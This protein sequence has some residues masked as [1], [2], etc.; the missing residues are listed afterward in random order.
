MNYWQENLEFFRK[1]AY[2]IYNKMQQAEQGD[3]PLEVSYLQDKKV[4]QVKRDNIHVHLASLFDSKREIKKT[5]ERCDKDAGLVLLLGI[6]NLALIKE[7][8]K[9]FRQIRRFIIVEPSVNIFNCAMKNMSVRDIFSAYPDTNITI[10]LQED[11]DIANNY[12]RAFMTIN[13]YETTA[14]VYTVPYAFVFPYEKQKLA[15]FVYFG[16][17]QYMVTVNTKKFFRCA[18]HINEW[19]NLAVEA[20]PLSALQKIFEQLPVIVVSAGPSLNKNIHLLK[21]VGNRAIIITAGSGMSILN[22]HGIKPHFRFCVEGN[23]FQERLFDSLDVNDSPLVFISAMYHKIVQKYE[24]NSFELFTSKSNPIKKYVLE[25][26]SMPMSETSSGSSVSNVAVFSSLTLG[27]KKIILM[28]QDL[29]FTGNKNYAEGAWTSDKEN[30]AFADQNEKV[31]LKDLYG[32]DVTTEGSYLSIKEALELAA[33]WNKHAHFINA[34]EGGLPVKGYEN[35]TFAAVLQEDLS[36][37]DIDIPQYI[38][39]CLSEYKS[40]PARLEHKR[41][42]PIVEG[43][44]KEL[45]RFMHKMTKMSQFVKYDIN[46]K[47][48]EKIRKQHEI[49]LEDKIYNVIYHGAFGD[50]EKELRAAL[51]SD[52]KVRRRQ[53]LDDYCKAIFDMINIT[54]LLGEEYISGEDKYEFIWQL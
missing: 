29:C 49:V 24:K 18:W 35:K 12:Y 34:T 20:P 5:L 52:D 25:R 53:A 14:F 27:C 54:K 46:D 2:E 7:I 42:V 10:L 48:V 19:K 1:N 22:T 32:D 4:F 28:G 51:S 11:L 40:S 31:F 45:Q 6:G 36:D 16:D 37:G 23:S 9:Y 21:E 38:Q 30:K 13:P 50:E 39:D 15:Q 43:L 44:L 26:L 47:M 33:D 41:I 8:K 3:S 17:C